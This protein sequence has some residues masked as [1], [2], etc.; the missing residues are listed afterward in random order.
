MR[1]KIS[2]R[3]G[4]GVK[5]WSLPRKLIVSVDDAANAKK[6]SQ[7]CAAKKNKGHSKLVKKIKNEL[8]NERML[9]VDIG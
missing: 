6:K 2:I 4:K 1:I 8:K 9:A 7:I 3:G 5:Y